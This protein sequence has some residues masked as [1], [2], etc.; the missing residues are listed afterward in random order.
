MTRSTRI[1]QMWIILIYCWAFWSESIENINQKCT[2]IGICNIKARSINPAKLLFVRLRVVTLECQ[3]VRSFFRLGFCSG[4]LPSKH[5]RFRMCQIF[6]IFLRP[7]ALMLSEIVAKNITEGWRVLIVSN[8]MSNGTIKALLQDDLTGLVPTFNEK[9]LVEH[10]DFVTWIWKPC[11]LRVLDTN[12]PHRIPYALRHILA[13]EL[14][15]Q[16]HADK[17]PRE[18]SHTRAMFESYYA[19]ILAE[20]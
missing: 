14:I 4:K 20:N 5:H 1:W 7:L 19:E 10:P 8:L 16:G 18:M 3:K 12:V 2:A 17:R 13:A 6:A 9:G 15:S 11:R